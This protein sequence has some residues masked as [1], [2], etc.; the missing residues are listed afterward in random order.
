MAAEDAAVVVTLRANLKDYEAALKSAVRSTERAAKAAETAVSGIGRR[1]SAAPISQA[2]QK[3]SQQIANDARILQFQLNDIFSGVASGQGIRAVQMQLGQIAQQLGGGGLMAGAR[4][5]GSAFV[6]M[7]NPI[8]LAVVAF[9]ALATVAASYFSDTEKDAEAASKELEKQAGAIRKLADEYGALFP[10]L[11][12]I[13]NLRQA[14]ADAAGKAE[15]E[16]TALAGAYEETKKSDERHGCRYR[17]N[18]FHVAST[19]HVGRKYRQASDRLRQA[20]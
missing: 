13:A 7:I 14:E 19:R 10:E 1:A 11:E 4:T 5:L 3:S 18:R 17:G 20:D 8:N 16:Q 6:G 9:G 15:A 12:R 2:F